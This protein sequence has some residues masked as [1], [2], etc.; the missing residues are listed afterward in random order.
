MSLSDIIVLRCLYKEIVNVITEGIIY[1]SN[2]IFI[3]VNI[4]NNFN[5]LSRS[6]GI[7]TIIMI[8]MD[9]DVNVNVN[10]QIFNIKN[11]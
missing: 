10:G 7:F 8:G 3:S 5:T 6:N 11:F 2:K 4:N 1:L 9:V